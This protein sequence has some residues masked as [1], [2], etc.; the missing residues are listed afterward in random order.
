V[1]DEHNLDVGNQL[2]EAGKGAVAAAPA[3]KVDDFEARLQ[4]LKNT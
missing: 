2:G 3:A 1:A 4:N